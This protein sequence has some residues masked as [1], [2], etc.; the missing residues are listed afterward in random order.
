MAR[1]GSADGGGVCM[2]WFGVDVCRI[3]L[4]S[5]ELRFGGDHWVGNNHRV[6]I[7]GGGS[8]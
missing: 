4:L 6:V 2:G 8:G 1:A 5:F 3:F 7:E